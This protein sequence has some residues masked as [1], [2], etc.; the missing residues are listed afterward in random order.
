MTEESDFTRTI[1]NSEITLIPFLRNLANSIEENKI[2][3]RQ[4]QNVSD[5][6]MKYHF[7]EEV[8]KDED[9]DD[10]SDP[11][12]ASGEFDAEELVKFLALGWYVYCIIL[13]DS[14]NKTHD[15]DNNITF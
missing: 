3:P 10:S 8:A 4:L 9:E 15:L 11:I 13:K 7:D 12:G 2:L 14:R 6:F 1:T 5:F